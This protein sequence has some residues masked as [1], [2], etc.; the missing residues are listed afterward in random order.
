[1]DVRN[2]EQTLNKLT[3]TL[4][5]PTRRSIYLRVRS[6]PEP[7]TATLVANEFGIHPNVARHHLDRLTEEGYLEVTRRRPTG[8]T[9]PG[10]GRPAKC[11]AATLKEIDLQFPTRRYDLLIDLLVRIVLHLA[12]GDGLQIA[13]EIGRDFGRE[14]ASG[15]TTTGDG[16]LAASL[17]TVASLMQKEGFE[18]IADP[19]GEKLLTEHC[20]FSAGKF[21]HPEVLCSLDRGIMT[22]IFEIVDPQRA[23]A[24][25]ANLEMDHACVTTV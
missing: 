2:L 1:M 5:D 24:L 14:L 9:G 6:S 18:I 19:A 21:E 17:E 22:G 3:A 10:A 15:I 4:G 16:D 11:Y 12:P 7:L 25:E 20:P 23:A 8:K 13:L